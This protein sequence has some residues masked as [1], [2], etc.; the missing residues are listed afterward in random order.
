MLVFFWRTD[1]SFGPC[2]WEKREK[3]EKKRKKIYISQCQ[4]L[5]ASFSLKV[6]PKVQYERRYLY[7]SL[8]KACCILNQAVKPA[9]LA[10]SPCPVS[11]K[12][13]SKP[14][15]SKLAQQ[16]VHSTLVFNFNQDFLKLIKA[17]V[18]IR[19]ALWIVTTDILFSL[20]EQ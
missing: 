15:C 11:F 18:I 6:M 10:G 4:Q 1:G 19:A 14:F 2:V 17:K 8:H 16:L 13:L 3:K 9:Q 7:Y 20:G 12:A 5:H